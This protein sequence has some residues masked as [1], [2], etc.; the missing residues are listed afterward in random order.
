[1]QVKADREARLPRGMKLVVDMWPEGDRSDVLACLA[2]H[3]LISC[4]D[5]LPLAESKCSHWQ[6]IWRTTEVS[7]SGRQKGRNGYGWGSKEG[8]KGG[9]IDPSEAS[10]RG[11]L[12]QAPFPSHCR[13]SFSPAV[14]PDAPYADLFGFLR[15]LSAS[16][17]FSGFSSSS[18]S[19]TFSPPHPLLL[20]V[21][22]I[23]GA[24]LSLTKALNL[25]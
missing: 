21:S 10:T 9:V 17:L 1:M 24:C 20:S 14:D 18:L 15:F 2:S 7:L 4:L 5:L 13:A 8:T 11:F 3:P 12:S 16:L 6:R 22:P 25:H 23:L 19:L